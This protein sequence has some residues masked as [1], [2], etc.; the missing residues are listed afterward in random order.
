MISRNCFKNLLVS[1]IYLIIY[2]LTCSQLSSQ[3]YDF[4]KSIFSSSD[5]KKLE[6]TKFY[7]TQAE[8]LIEEAN[9]L[10]MQTFAVQG[11]YELD[12]DKIEKKVKQLENKA[13]KKQIE[14]AKYYEL[15]NQT[16]FGIY[17][18]YIEKF[19]SD[20]EGDESVYINARLIEEQSNDLY[21]QASTLRSEAAKISDQKEKVKNL[22]SAYDLE[23]KSLEK[24]LS[25]LGI[26]YGID[27]TPGEDRAEQVSA[28]VTAIEK[29][30]PGEQQL[31]Y[32]EPADKKT[33]LPP[34]RDIIISEPTTA[35]IEEDIMV[36]QMI[37]DLYNQYMSDSTR[38]PANV[39]TPEMLSG[40]THFDS[41]QILNIWY[42]YAFDTLYEGVPPPPPPP[43]KLASAD[44]A[45]EELAYEEQT[46]E[47]LVPA[48]YEE[49]IAVVE[50]D[51]DESY[52]IP[53]GDEVIYRVQ[54]AAHKTQLTQRALSKI[55]YGNK[56]IEM[57]NEQGWFKYSI[58]DFIT[59]E[60]ADKFRK[61]CGVKNA[62][63]VAY[64]KGQMFIPTG[65][66]EEVAA[67]YSQTAADIIKSD[68]DIGL[69]FRVQIAANRVPLTREQLSRIYKDDYPV[70]MIE[71]EGWFK[72]QILGVRL[73]SDALRLLRNSQVKGAFVIAYDEGVRQ[74][75][76]IAV[77]H[78]SSLEQEVQTY[79]R[80][81]RLNDIEWHVQVAASH[82]PL[83][84]DELS[85]IYRGNRKIS[86]IIEE[87]WYKYR[88]KAGT[89][90]SAAKEI[91]QQCGVPNAFIVSYYR[92][93]K[94]PINRAIN[95]YY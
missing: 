29:T 30:E 3:Q 20:F 63:I 16:K 40:I 71:E 34:V 10:Y 73:F 49:K 45:V 77:K 82:I 60:D 53:E 65:I 90:Y 14:A 76:Y 75:L 12:E 92:A 39:L 21:F 89:S 61:Q 93:K 62:F 69:I 50:E 54:I 38:Y 74:N 67:Q 42:S 55:Y 51:V 91:K 17:K 11:D 15:I 78:S 37:I 7:E 88:L 79:G 47:Q 1:P 48:Q 52:Y 2:L 83:T 84:K 70:E 27:Y 33:E 35:R 9:E 43:E 22:N 46:E 31:Y 6:K 59:Y 85:R 56:K 87:G 66:S 19:W 80:K 58:G 25:A 41:D 81:G 32:R 4:I 13:Q 95:D 24:Q 57:L 64:R 23:I 68:Y 86:L 72:Y 36:N 44:T 5:L 18:K 94:V 8:Q 28:D 26:Y